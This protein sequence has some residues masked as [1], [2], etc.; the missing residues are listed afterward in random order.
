MA[1]QHNDTEQDRGREGDDHGRVTVTVVNE[2]DGRTFE[3]HAGRGQTV[4]FAIEQVYAKVGRERQ[5]DDRL[6]CDGTG[7]DVFGFA[8][9]KIKDYFEAGHC[10]DRM[11][12]FVGP[13]GGAQGT[14]R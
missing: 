1:T 10:P 14:G 13:T 5:A 7:E 12:A 11:W 3:V 9:M 8:D 6:S 2:D 4:G